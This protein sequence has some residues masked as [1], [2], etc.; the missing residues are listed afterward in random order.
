MPE[1]IEL[2]KMTGD[3]QWQDKAGVIWKSSAQIASHSNEV[4]PVALQL[5]VLQRIK[6]KGYN[7]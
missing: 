7:P 1:W 6:E 2:S 3:S 4:G 5:D